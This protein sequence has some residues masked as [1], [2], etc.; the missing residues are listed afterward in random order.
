MP[1]ALEMAKDTAPA[2]PDI[3]LMHMPPIV[4]ADVTA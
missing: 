3:V 2:N 1:E 4:M